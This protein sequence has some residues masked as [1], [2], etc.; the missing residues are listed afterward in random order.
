MSTRSVKG[1]GR[2]ASTH[3]PATPSEKCSLMNPAALSILV[4]ATVVVFSRAARA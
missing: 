1:A 3:P 4:A 2:T